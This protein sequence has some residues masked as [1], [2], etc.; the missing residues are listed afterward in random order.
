MLILNAKNSTLTFQLDNGSLMKIKPGEVSQPFVPSLFQ[1]QAILAMGTP[2]QIGIVLSSS[3]EMDLLRQMNGSMAYLKSSV[4]VARDELLNG[5]K[6]ESPEVNVNIEAEKLKAEMDD[7]DK[8]IKVLQDR[9]KELETQLANSP[10]VELRQN[11]KVAN[12]E[13]TKVKS[14][15]AEA[16]NK[17]DE[18]T[19]TIADRDKSI[20]D[21]TNEKGYVEQQLGEANRKVTDSVAANTDLTKKLEEANATIEEL[22]KT[23]EVGPVQG[24]SEEVYSEVHTKLVA[25]EEEI[26]KLKKDAVTLVDKYT[27]AK[28]TLTSVMEKFGI[29]YNGTEFV[30]AE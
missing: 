5:K 18:L 16:G 17:I 28:T 2:D 23:S 15:L 12:E 6:I 4:Q 10:A 20:L 14:N 22:R 3:Y 7:K 19:S 24:V 29:T 1:I 13:L 27:Q 26:N 9:V 8:E 11:L 30:K 21:L 25:A